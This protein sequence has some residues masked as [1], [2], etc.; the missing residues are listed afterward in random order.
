M[1][2]PESP[3]PRA[4]RLEGHSRESG[5][6]EGY[7]GTLK[8]I[9]DK[10]VSIIKASGC[11]P[12]WHSFVTLLLESGGE[13]QTIQALRGY[14][15]RSTPLLSTPVRNRRKKGVESPAGRIEEDLIYASGEHCPQARTVLNSY[16][17]SMEN[18]HHEYDVSILNGASSNL[19]L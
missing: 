8:F 18:D 9:P 11:P 13:I 2:L 3:P 10:P 1:H 15:D 5:N 16:I 12:P 14:Q 19:K 6:L 17:F 7:P 4:Q